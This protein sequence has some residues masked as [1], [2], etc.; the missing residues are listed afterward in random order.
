MEELQKRLEAVA[1]KKSKPFCYGCYK[2]APTGRCPSCF[3]DDLMRATHGGVEY[4]IDWVVKELVEE[5]LKPADTEAAFEES[6]RECYPEEVTIAW[7]TYD[8]VS[9][10]KELDPMS[11]KLA[12]SEWIDQEVSED[13]LVT[14]DGGST[15]Y[16]RS[17]IENYLDEAEGEL[18]AAG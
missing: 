10:V 7:I 2:E 18:E 15:H 17:D 11:W 6:V 5:N 14:F 1:W 9:A 4:G 3:S 12:A 8:T 16:S 13:N